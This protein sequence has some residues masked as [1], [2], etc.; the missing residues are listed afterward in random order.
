MTRALVVVV[1]ALVGCVVQERRGVPLYPRSEPPRRR[2]EVALLRGPIVTVDGAKV[3]SRDDAF[4]LLPGCHIVTVGGRTGKV[5]PLNHAGWVGTLP[6]LTYAFRMRAGGAYSI[7]VEID[8]ALGLGPNGT[9]HV[10]AREQ[11]ARGLTSIVPP[12]QGRA[13]IDECRQWLPVDAKASPGP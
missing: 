10:V 1:I 3:V 11:D 9:G 5:D 2:D 7:D 8:P 6:P 13:S 4:E 12:V